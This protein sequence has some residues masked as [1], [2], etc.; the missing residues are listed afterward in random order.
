VLPGFVR[1]DLNRFICDDPA[2]ARPIEANTP[3]GRIGTPDEVA[4]VVVFLCSDLAR[5]VTG[6]SIVIDGGSLLVNAQ[7]DPLLRGLVGG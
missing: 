5:Y 4:D 6:H 2:L 7:V 3:L 1:T